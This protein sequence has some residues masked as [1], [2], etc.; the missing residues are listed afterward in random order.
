ML[1]IGNN[2]NHLVDGSFPI[3]SIYV[4]PEALKHLPKSVPGSRQRG[5]PKARKRSPEA[6]NRPKQAS[7]ASKH[8]PQTSAHSNVIAPMDDDMSVNT[9]LTSNTAKSSSSVNVFTGTKDFV[10]F[11][12][13]AGTTSGCIVEIQMKDPWDGNFEIR[14]VSKTEGLLASKVVTKKEAAKI[15]AW[16]ETNKGSSES[17]FELHQ[18]LTSLFQEADQRGGPIQHQKVLR[19]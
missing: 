14:I 3:S 5:R 6:K 7:S 2:K 8:S 11:G 10:V 13:E 16:Y 18:L 4:D 9:G 1:A 12:R 17:I 19:G 15:E